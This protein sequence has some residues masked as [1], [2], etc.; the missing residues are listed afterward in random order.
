MGAMD[1]GG[2]TAAL[3][4]ADR[5]RQ[6]TELRQSLGDQ[7]PDTLAALREL[8]TAHREAADLAGALPLAEE[9]LAET[10]Q[11]LGP[12]HPESLSLAVA[13]ANWCQH[14]GDVARAADDLTGLIP[15]LDS[16]L[17]RDPP[18]TLTARHMLAS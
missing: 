5:E 9:L 3:T 10:R 18:D 15:L 12:Q 4:V 17:G 13:V 7:H 1:T 6:A 11:R 2:D 14:V 8:M 16:E